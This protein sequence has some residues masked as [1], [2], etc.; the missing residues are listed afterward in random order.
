MIIMMIIVSIGLF[1]LSVYIISHRTK[2]IDIRKVLGDSIPHYE[3]IMV[4]FQASLIISIFVF[5]P[6]Y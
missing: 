3:M 5:R 6:D 1:G 4:A 2:E